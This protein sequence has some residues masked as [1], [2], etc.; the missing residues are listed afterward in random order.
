MDLW[1]AL[2]DNLK[3]I[4]EMSV[5]YLAHDF[6][7]YTTFNE[8]RTIE[9]GLFNVSSLPAEDSAALASAA[10]ELWNEEAAKSKRNAKAIQM[11]REMAKSAGRLK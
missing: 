6:H 10:Q 7:N 3:A 8:Q 5:I 9:S 1:K 2:P 11:L 4:I